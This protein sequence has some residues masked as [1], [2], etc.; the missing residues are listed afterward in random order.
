MRKEREY[1]M[2]SII[3]IPGNRFDAAYALH[4]MLQR[5]DA[6]RHL[7]YSVAPHAPDNL[8]QLLASATSR[9][10]VFGE[11]SDQTIFGTPAGNHAFRA[12][13]DMI[14]L[15]LLADTSASGEYRV[16]RQQ[17]LEAERV[18]GA[19][20]ADLVWAD[21]YGQTLHYGMYGCFPTDQACFTWNYATQ[22]V[23][24]KS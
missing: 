22:K 17:A 11:Y 10:V 23:V 12:W 18:C 21:L 24:V 5:I 3:R 1:T 13:H 7:T 20:L 19:T 8:P 15:D 16:A 14:H 2:S 9:L 6:Q 4:T